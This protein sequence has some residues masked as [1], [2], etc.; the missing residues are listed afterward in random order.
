L[1]T[2]TKTRGELIQE[3]LDRLR[4]PI[5]KLYDE[6]L[7]EL[8]RAEAEHAEILNYAKRLETQLKGFDPEF[9]PKREDYLKA[10]EARLS[11]EKKKGKASSNGS[12]G[13]SMEKCQTI[14]EAVVKHAGS[15]GIT[16]A[17]VMEHTGLKKSAV[18]KGL[19]VMLSDPYQHVYR[20]GYTPRPHG[21]GKPAPLYKPMKGAEDAKLA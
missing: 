15:K 3:Q 20:A 16:P 1:T 19:R 8:A 13:I 2:Q 7:E 17:E 14:L 18:D 5:D 21:G 10:R 6:T 9:I 12:L 11:W 4:A